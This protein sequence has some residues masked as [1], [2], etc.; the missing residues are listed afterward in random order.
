MDKSTRLL[1]ANMGIARGVFIL[2]ENLMKFSMIT[3]AI[4]TLVNVVLN[5]LWIP[6]YGAKNIVPQQIKTTI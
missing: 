3:M 2:T 4:G 6:D 5:Y 1:F